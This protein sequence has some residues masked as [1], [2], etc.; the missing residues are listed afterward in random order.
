MEL[1][2]PNR[3]ISEWLNPPQEDNKQYSFRFI[4]ITNKKKADSEI[5]QFLQENLLYTYEDK[6]S[7]DFSLEGGSV[8]YIREYL[9]SLF[10]NDENSD[11]ERNKIM[12][13]S[14]DFGEATTKLLLKTLYN[15]DSLN[16]LKYKLHS[17]RSVFGTDLISFDNIKNPSLMSFCE[18]KTRQKLS[19]EKGK[20][21]NGED[22][23]LYISVIAHNSL[24]YDTKQGIN[25]VLRFM[26]VKAKETNDLITAKTFREILNGNKK[27]NKAYEIF[28]LTEDTKTNLTLLLNAL[29]HLQNKLTPLSISIILVDD[30]AYIRNEV[31]HG[32]EN[33]AYTVYGVNE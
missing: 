8:D 30:L 13:Q 25:S 18:V 23:Q 24:K 32:I 17:G 19:K 20:N 6:D 10:P 15:K 26:M 7:L 29:E 22:E 14:G 4:K 11:S 16:K 2:L 27:I 5:I 9:K 3:I 28:I 31:W 12:V 33:Y 1:C 21:E